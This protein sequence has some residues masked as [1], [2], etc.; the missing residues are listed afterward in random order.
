MEIVARRVEDDEVHSRGRRVVD[1]FQPP[2]ERVV[3]RV[4]VGA[5][6]DRG[7]LRVDGAV[8]ADDVVGQ[9]RGR[10]NRRAVADPADAA[11]VALDLR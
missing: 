1:A 7:A 2:E 8:G 6:R 11:E 4:E 9:A 5:L 3:E 10:L